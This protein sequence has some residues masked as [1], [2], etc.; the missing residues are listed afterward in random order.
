MKSTTD[1][2]ANKVTVAKIAKVD[3]AERIERALTIQDAMTALKAELEEIKE[4]FHEHFNLNKT[5][6]K[7]ITTK[8][9]AVLK[10]T[11]SYTVAPEK[12]ESLKGIFGDTCSVMVTEK[13]TF[14]ASAALKKLL[15]DAD[16]KHADIIR[17]AVM[18]KTQPAVTFIPLNVL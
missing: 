10:K 14:G 8:G 12:I 15:G 7:V 11:N 5:Q 9:A 1:T 16:Y 18:I 13:R 17:N 3:F 2:A 6:E 4:L